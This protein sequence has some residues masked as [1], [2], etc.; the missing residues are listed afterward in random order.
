MLFF[1]SIVHTYVMYEDVHMLVIYLVIYNIL[2]TATKY[3]EKKSMAG[4]AKKGE[5]DRPF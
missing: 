1:I 3:W 4:R 2:Y 5:A